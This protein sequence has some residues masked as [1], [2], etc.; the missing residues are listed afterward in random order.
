MGEENIMNKKAQI[1]T[2]NRTHVPEGG[3]IALASRES[4]EERHC[5]SR[6]LVDAFVCLFDLVKLGSEW[7]E[8]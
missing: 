2:F 8:R 3:K 6:I 5:Q 4:G 7:G 1:I